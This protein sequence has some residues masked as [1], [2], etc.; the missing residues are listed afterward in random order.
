MET[1]GKLVHVGKVLERSGLV[2]TQGSNYY[3][4][5]RLSPTQNGMRSGKL[6][7]PLLEYEWA[8]VKSRVPNQSGRVSTTLS[9][10]DRL[11]ADLAVD[12]ERVG[13][14]GIP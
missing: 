9:G 2:T 4:E 7:Q 10:S 5:T 14:G 6:H 13:V 3:G 12:G 11:G 1:Q 8:R